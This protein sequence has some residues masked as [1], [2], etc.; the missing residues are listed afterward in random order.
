MDGFGASHFLKY[1]CNFR[2]AFLQGAVS[3]GVVFQVSQSL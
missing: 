3:I 2:V 1:L